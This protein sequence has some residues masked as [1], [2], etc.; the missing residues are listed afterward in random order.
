MDY[1]EL[2]INFAEFIN[3][4][5]WELHVVLTFK[6]NVSFNTAVKHAKPWLCKIKEN[7]SEIKFGAILLTSRPTT[8]HPHIHCLMVSD[9]RYPKRLLDIPLAELERVWPYM[10]H[11]T[12]KDEW[13]NRVISNYFAKSHNFMPHRPN[14][15]DFHYF[16]K[17][18]MNQLKTVPGDIRY[19]GVLVTTPP[20]QKNILG[21]V[22]SGHGRNH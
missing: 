3:Q 16:R 19:G 13:T 7:N 9:P 21:G 17:N 15:W 6:Q 11:I 1:K 2:E 18:L 4:W 14:D 10:C 8:N 5:D 22:H 20:S 12:T